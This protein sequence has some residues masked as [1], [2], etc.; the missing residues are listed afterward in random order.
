MLPG[1]VGHQRVGGV[2]HLLRGAVILRQ[3]H[4]V[5]FGF[6]PFGETQNVLDR[7]GTKRVD[8]L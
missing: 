6:E 2:E 7:R 8:R 4:H 5:G 3:H 1:A